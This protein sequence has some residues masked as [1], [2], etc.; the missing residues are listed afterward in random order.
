MNK[1]NAV[2]EEM[3]Q[4]AMHNVI[5]RVAESTKDSMHYR[6]GDL[7]CLHVSAHM[8]IDKTVESLKH[9]MGYKQKA[10]IMMIKCSDEKNCE[11]LACI[12]KDADDM[13]I[14]ILGMNIK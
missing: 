3:Q 6:I 14:K 2:M 13:I 11:Q 7:H 12:I 10:S 5:S 4:L 9:I 8:D 1:T